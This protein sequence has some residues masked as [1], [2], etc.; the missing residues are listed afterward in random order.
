M[1]K[2]KRTLFRLPN[3]RFLAAVVVV[4]ATAAA[5]VA[6]I[7]LLGCNLSDTNYCLGCAASVTSTTTHVISCGEGVSHYSCDGFIHGLSDC[8]EHYA[9]IDAIAKYEVEIDPTNQDRL[10]SDIK[11]DYSKAEAELHKAADC[12]VDGHFNCDGKEHSQDRCAASPEPSSHTHTY[13]EATCIAPATCTVEGCGETNGEADASNH[14]GGTE[15]KNA[16]TATCAAEGYSGDTYCKGCNAVI[17]KGSE[18]AKST[19]HG[20]GTEVK[21]KKDA[22]CCETGY[23]G[24][25]YCKGCGAKISGGS[26]V[27][28]TGQH[29]AT[30]C[31]TTG[32]HAHD[33]KDHSG[34]DC[35]ILGHYACDGKT[36]KDW[37]CITT[38]QAKDLI[39][40]EVTIANPGTTW[41]YKIG[42][43]NVNNGN[44]SNYEHEVVLG[45]YSVEV[46]FSTMLGSTFTIDAENGK[47]VY[48]ADY[49]PSAGYNAMIV[50][51]ADPATVT[52]SEKMLKTETTG[53]LTQRTL[54]ITIK[55]PA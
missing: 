27:A 49:S 24:D 46:R 1:K 15:V 34:A 17:Q 3:N 48:I 31:N 41:S 30:E 38:E 22:T 25:T 12:G 39:V 6:T 45:G 11:A 4:S 28:A 36:H 40:V 43:H 19:T 9:C 32:H 2:S 5:L 7:P 44:L 37:E 29:P 18:T 35:Q 21:N 52:V 33:K 54:F 8:G 53:G 20:G 23:S 42:G 26:T 14:T 16:K 55:D 13:G 50:N 47:K 10:L 51:G